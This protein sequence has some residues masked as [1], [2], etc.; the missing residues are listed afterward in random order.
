MKVDDKKFKTWQLPSPL[1]L[2]WILNPG[3]AINELV[4]G[5]RIPKVTLI[6]ET[7]DAPLIERQ[8]VPCPHCHT[9]H[10][11]AIWSK[12]GA[13]QNWF[14][15]VCPTC[16]KI[17]PCLWNITSLL[18]LAV[19]SPLWWWF[20]QPLKEKW[21]QFKLR[22]YATTNFDVPLHENSTSWLKIG[23]TF[24][25]LMFVLALTILW[26]NDNLADKSLL[27]ITIVCALAGVGFGGA[28]KLL[29]GTKQV[30]KD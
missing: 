30:K 2:H 28:M 9:I 6:D 23:V 24:G 11:G 4:L 26:L 1:L 10:Q 29:L 22:Q 17:I 14:G 21:R 19:F 25:I 12:K 3:L 7:S 13:F 5:Q 20:H 16:E 15:L 8:Y 27:S 18:L